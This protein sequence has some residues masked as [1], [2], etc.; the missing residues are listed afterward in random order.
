M[1]YRLEAQSRGIGRESA[2]AR[3]IDVI[4]D[5]AAAAEPHSRRHGSAK[6]EQLL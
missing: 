5:T 4:Q 3:E 6:A 2:D 1:L